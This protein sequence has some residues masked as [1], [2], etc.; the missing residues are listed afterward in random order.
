MMG[1]ATDSQPMPTWPPRDGKRHL[2][3]ELPA[4]LVEHLDARASYEG[5]SRPAYLRKLI[6]RDIEQHASSPQA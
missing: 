2:T 4:E 1:A 3:L 6:V 5:C